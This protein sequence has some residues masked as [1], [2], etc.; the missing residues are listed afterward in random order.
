MHSKL[1]NNHLIAQ[2]ILNPLVTN[3]LYLVLVDSY[4]LQKF[5]FKKRDS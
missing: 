4:V 5:L 2:Y 1:K 3:M